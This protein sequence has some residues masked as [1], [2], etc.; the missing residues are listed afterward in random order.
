MLLLIPYMVLVVAFKSAFPELPE[1][2]R[3]TTVIS[4]MLGWAVFFYFG[5]RWSGFK[6]QPARTLWRLTRRRSALPRPVFDRYSVILLLCLL[7][8]F[9]FVWLLSRLAS[10]SG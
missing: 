9:G 10:G 3:W 6:S 4:V 2:H 1:Q 8:A 5:S 7:A